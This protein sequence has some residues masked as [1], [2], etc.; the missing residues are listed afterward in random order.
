MRYTPASVEPQRL[1]QL[2]GMA[3]LF[4][5]LLGSTPLHSAVKKCQLAEVQQLVQKG[6]QVDG[7]DKAR[8]RN[9]VCMR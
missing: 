7:K 3:S 6:A 2:H 4:S 1:P 9:W 5:G 8:P